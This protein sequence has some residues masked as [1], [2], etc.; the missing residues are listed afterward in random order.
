MK[1]HLCTSNAL[2]QGAVQYQYITFKT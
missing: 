2:P 1:A